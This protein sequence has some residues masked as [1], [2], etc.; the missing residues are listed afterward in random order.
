MPIIILFSVCFN[1]FDCHRYDLSDK[2]LKSVLRNRIYKESGNVTATSRFQLPAETDLE[3]AVT[4]FV[5]M[6]ILKGKFERFPPIKAVASAPLAKKMSPLKE[7]EKAVAI[8]GA[9]DPIVPRK[10]KLP[11]AVVGAKRAKTEECKK[12]TSPCKIIVYYI[13][14]C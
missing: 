13:Y 11:D 7:I 5:E 9:V 2:K 12:K 8:S 1:I 6:S 3:N 14:H 10:R 4:N